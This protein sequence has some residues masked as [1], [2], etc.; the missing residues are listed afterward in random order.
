MYMPLREKS[1]VKVWFYFVF[2]NS[3]VSNIMTLIE[4]ASFK[5]NFFLVK[6]IFM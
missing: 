3:P 1:G 4:I 2:H 5:E 6:F